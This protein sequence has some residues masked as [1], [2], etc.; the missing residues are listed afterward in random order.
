MDVERQYQQ[1][2]SKLVTLAEDFMR[3]PPRSLYEG[4]SKE[5]A[6]TLQELTIDSDGWDKLDEWVKHSTVVLLRN[7]YEYFQTMDESTKLVNIGDFEK[8]SFGIA[9]AFFPGLIAQDLV[10]VQPMDGPTS[11]I[12]FL[13]FLFGSSKG[14]ATEG[15]VAAT[16]NAPYYPSKHIDSESVG[17]SGTTNYTGTLS[18][19]PVIPGS[20]LFTDGTLVVTDDGNGSLI[21]DVGAGNN[22]INYT[23]GEYDVTFSGNT[24]AA[25][26]VSY[27][28]NQEMNNTLPELY[29]N[30]SSIPVVAEDFILNVI[31]GLRAQQD[32]KRTHGVSAETEL[33]AAATNEIKF[34][35]DQMIINE[36][37]ANAGNSV[38]AWTKTSTDVWE[39]YKN[40]FVDK[41][42]EASNLIL[43]ST[44]R[45]VGNWIVAGLDVCAVIESLASNG[46]FQRDPNVV[47][48]APG[49]G[50]HKLG[51][52][53]GQWTVYKNTFM[54]STQY[55]MGH[56]GDSLYD[57]G[58]VWAPYIPAFTIPTYIHKDLS[59][60]KAIAT[61]G[62]KKLINGDFYCT[63]SITGG[64]WS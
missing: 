22:T 52:L 32:L 4:R 14:Q 58:Y 29:M 63:G 59:A 50:I 28:F 27:D 25:V 7:L 35:I 11:L 26:T 45:G 13:E 43:N 51:N 38:T 5:D 48:R 16:T 23:T 17:V 49:R 30:L 40:T 9:R 21:G 19:T 34:A 15:Q 53:D 61:S 44:K 8:W 57:M 24:S 37:I 2:Q 64:I 42:I 55:V 41:L 33:V 18:W 3:R 10:S 12:F 54:T 56:K 47:G 20:M 39:Q 60:N 1:Y 6:V 36:I 31:W 62:A 46:R